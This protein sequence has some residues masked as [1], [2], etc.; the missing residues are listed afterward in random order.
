MVTTSVL[1]LG[2][3]ADAALS[4]HQGSGLD[5]DALLIDP[6]GV[7]VAKPGDELRMGGG[8]HADDLPDTRHRDG[9][10]VVYVSA[11]VSCSREPAS[12][13]CS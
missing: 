2:N 11:P 8:H 6:L 4:G 9:D 13:E 5:G 7:A 12:N 1:G 10:D 3:R